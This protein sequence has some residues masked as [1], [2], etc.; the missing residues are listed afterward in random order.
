MLPWFPFPIVEGSFKFVKQDLLFFLNP[1]QGGGADTNQV[2]VDN[3]Q[4][5]HDPHFCPFF[6]FFFSN[7][8][9][10]PHN[11]FTLPNTTITSQFK[12]N[13]ITKNRNSN[14]PCSILHQ[15]PCNK[16]QEKK[17]IPLNGMHTSYINFN[18]KW[19]Q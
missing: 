10:K 18:A 6:N 16:S 19:V 14:D 15:F 13:P 8:N 11:F 5:P 12:W 3:Q 2:V 9:T 17:T 4:P 1:Y 7:P